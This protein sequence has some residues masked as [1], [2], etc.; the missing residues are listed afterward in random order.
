MPEIVRC[1]CKARVA[2]RGDVV[3]IA[4]DDGLI[5]RADRCAKDLEPELVAQLRNFVEYGR[6]EALY[7]CP[8]FL[9][10]AKLGNTPPCG[11]MWC[12][13]LYLLAR[14]ERGGRCV[15]CACVEDD[16]CE[17]GCSWT[18]AA[19]VC[20]DSHADVAAIVAAEKLFPAVA[21]RAA[22]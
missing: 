12:V 10:G 11:C 19:K 2:L 7:P 8:S 13:A 20:C 1:S 3:A 4:H 5:H 14:A 16:A 18:S 9:Q 6:S 15:I 22:R 17:G 21:R